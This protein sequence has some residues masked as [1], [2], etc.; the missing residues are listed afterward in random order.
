LGENLKPDKL[1]GGAKATIVYT[2][3]DISKDMLYGI[4]N[5]KKAGR[6]IIYRKTPNFKE[7]FPKIKL[8]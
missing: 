3:L 6:E 2:D 4:N 1:G 7:F 5:A 8:N